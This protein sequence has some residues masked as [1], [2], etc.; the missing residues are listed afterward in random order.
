MDGLRE[1]G[2]E[3]HYIGVKRRDL[4]D[5]MRGI[6]QVKPDDALVIFE[7]EP[8]ILGLW[9][10]VLAMAWLRLARRK[11]IVLSVHEIAPERYHEGRQIQWHLSRPVERKR[12]AE[13]L[14]LVLCVGDVVQCFVRY[15]VGLLCLGWVPHAVLVHSPKA[16]ENIQVAAVDDRVHYVP[17]V[18]RRIEGD[19]QTLRR[20]L[21]LPVAPFAFIIPGFLFRRKRMIEVIAQLPPGT[22][23]WI[24]GT[25]SPYDPGY[26]DEIQAY[27]AQ[28]PHRDR[29]RLS[30]DYDRLLEYIAAADAAVFYYSEG[31]QSGAASLAVGAGK[32]CIFSDLPAFVDLREAGLT[33]QSE[34]ELREA[35]E[36]IQ[37]PTCYGRLAEAAHSIREALSPAQIARRY[38]DWDGL[39]RG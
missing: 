32:P 30:H 17:H 33:V 9:G 4:G 16:A 34:P 3:V 28:C 1:V 20:E 5:L 31:Y 23:L 15:R 2:H 24:V 37:D 35:M 21:G 6:R 29:V 14:K 10:T 26:L 36:Q 19:K 39:G 13:L 25:R 27:L 7:Y 18:V 8:G 22:E 12:L 38:L 11:R